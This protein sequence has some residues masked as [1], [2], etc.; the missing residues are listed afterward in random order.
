LIGKNE[1]NSKAHIA[2]SAAEC[3]SSSSKIYGTKQKQ[4][5]RKAAGKVWYDP[6]LEQWSNG[7]HNN[8]TSF[9]YLF[10]QLIDYYL[11]YFNC[12]MQEGAFIMYLI[13]M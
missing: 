12:K 6:T 3:A 13:F 9:C 1:L 2:I 5:Y 4:F 11:T 7:E 8:F 10:I